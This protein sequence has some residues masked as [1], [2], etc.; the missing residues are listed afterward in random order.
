MLHEKTPKPSDWCP[1]ND[2]QTE[3]EWEEYFECRKNC[4]IDFSPEERDKL[5]KTVLSLDIWDPKFLEL[6]DMMP[7]DP[8]MA[9]AVKRLRGLKAVMHLNLCDAK[10]KYPDEF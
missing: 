5:R 1:E 4:D 6:G 9:M 7:E 3:E 8:E 10:E 2:P